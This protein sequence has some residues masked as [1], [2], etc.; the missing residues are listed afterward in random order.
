[1]KLQPLTLSL[2]AINLAL[3]LLLLTQLA[4]TNAQTDASVLRGRAL[5]LVDEQGKVRS[6]INVEASDE[7]VLRLLDKNGTIRVKLA[8]SSDGSG[9]VMLD[10]ETEPGVQILARRSGNAVNSNTTSISL[11]GPQGQQLLIK[12]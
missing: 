10:G 1:M 2:T 8:A 9:L 3:L 12:P 7:V 5:E 4:S 11:K 6:R